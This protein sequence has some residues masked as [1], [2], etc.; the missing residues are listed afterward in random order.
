M[1]CLHYLVRL[2]FECKSGRIFRTAP[3]YFDQLF[4]T[5]SY[6]S[7]TLLIGLLTFGMLPPSWADDGGTP[8][9]DHSHDDQHHQPDPPSFL[10]PSAKTRGAYE[11]WL[12]DQANTAG[13]SMAVPNGTHGG[14]IRIYDAADLLLPNPINNPFILDVTADLFP[15]ANLTTATH[16]ARIHG[17]LPSPD[18]RYMALNFVS[19]GH[20]GIVDGSSKKPVC[21]F[22]TTGTN[23]GR[24]NHM[25]FWTPNGNHIIV[26]NQNGKLLER[27]DVVR[28]ASGAVKEFVFNANASVDLV[29]GAGRI[30]AQPI[31]VTADPS[32]GIGCRVEGSVQDN[33]P[34]LTPFNLP[35]QSG[36]R[37]N[38]TVICPIPSSSGKHAF[39]TLGGGGMFVIDVR[40]APMAIV[41]EYDKTIINA[42]GCGGIE[43][44]SY[45]HMNTGTSAADKSEFSVYRFGIDYPDAPNFLPANTP[46]PIA[47]W[48][49][50]DNGQTLPGTNR[51][52]HGMV[53]T[54]DE[55]HVFDRVRNVVEIFPMLPPWDEMQPSDQ[56]DLT[57]SQ[58]CGTTLGTTASNDPTPDLADVSPDGQSIYVA[59]RGPYPLTVSHAA[60]GSCPGL[61][62]I[63][64]D[65]FSHRWTLQHVLDTSVLNYDLTRN[66]SDPHAV[67]MRRNTEVPGPLPLAGV[68]AALQLR[69]QLRRRLRASRS[70]AL[71]SP[72]ATGQSA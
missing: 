43:T 49:D 63:R 46:A 57:D 36:Q 14:K 55:L 2:H 34:T 20:L 4:R 51:D 48:Q 11:L 53:V 28:G 18:H 19:S 30:T 61:G 41:A 24:Q 47:V 66:L 65:P 64:R 33:Q 7:R 15:T 54:E 37:P 31:A 25:S 62:I 6:V 8:G 71:T 58:K 12:S 27:V 39:T 32:N 26:A 50:G 60:S 22:R 5:A 17:I 29:G 40:T 70:A 10:L 59:L 67:I 38:N 21:L 16:V 52:A 69:R 68:A 45:M 23:T 72:Q 42:A 9:G 56:Y 1:S 35:K 44:K 3:K 13:L